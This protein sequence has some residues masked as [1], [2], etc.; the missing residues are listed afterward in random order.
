MN[1]KYNPLLIILLIVIM[2][3][4]LFSC[5]NTSNN[6][7]IEEPIGLRQ[8]SDDRHKNVTEF[9]YGGCE[10]IR[11]GYGQSAW[12]SHKGNCINPIHKK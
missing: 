4:M 5:S 1:R 11:V 7:Q 10:Y 12:G 3:F 6:Q 8:K 2:I 9:T